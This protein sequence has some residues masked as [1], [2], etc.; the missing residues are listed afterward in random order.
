MIKIFEKE[1]QEY[2]KTCGVSQKEIDN[3]KFTELKKAVLIKIDMVRSL[4]YRDEFFDI[5]KF[6]AHSPASDD[7]GCDNEYIT[8]AEFFADSDSDGVDITDV[9]ASLANLKQS[10]IIKTNK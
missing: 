8:F 5:D 6:T 3:I 2:L 1:T 7:M 4:I 9:C 10:Q